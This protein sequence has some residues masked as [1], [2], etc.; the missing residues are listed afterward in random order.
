VHFFVGFSPV[1]LRAWV[2]RP[3]HVEDGDR[4]GATL[5]TERYRPIALAEPEIPE[6]VLDQHLRALHREAVLDFV[7]AVVR[8]HVDRESPI[9]LEELKDKTEASF[10]ESVPHVAR[11][12]DEVLAQNAE[13]VVTD[14]GH[15]PVVQLKGGSLMPSASLR[16]TAT[17]RQCGY[18]AWYDPRAERG[19][20]RAASGTELKFS[21]QHVE[22][23]SRPLLKKRRAH[24]PTVV[25]FT[26]SEK[27]ESAVGVK[28]LDDR[29][30]LRDGAF[31]TARELPRLVEA[32]VLERIAEA[33]S[34]QLG[35][36]LQE[37][38][39]ELEQSFIGGAR[40][41]ERL[42]FSS[43]AAYLESLS[44]VALDGRGGRTVVGPREQRAFGRL[45]SPPPP[46]AHGSTSLK[47]VP[48]LKPSP[49]LIAKPSSPPQ[50][51]PQAPTG[52]AA[53]E[54]PPPRPPSDPEAAVRPK[55]P[56][57]RAKQIIREV[58]IACGRNGL[59]LVPLTRL[60]AMCRERADPEGS[61]PKKLATLVSSIPDLELVGEGHGASARLRASRGD[62]KQ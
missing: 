14:S 35:L 22:A 29:M 62:A 51:K 49:K 33:R 41:C 57:E 52:S 61:F 11:L 54:R 58:V 30:S 43:L 60:G 5:D 39:Q 53:G 2:V 9:V 15:G 6:E 13:F 46:V 21:L 10:V 8:A 17:A 26:L 25:E 31:V 44:T 37:L 23:A 12:V 4:R 27:S 56:I 42:G 19:G 18:V 45:A 28:L 38:E 48:S 20:I 47:K 59:T 40:L 50:A 36:F 34:A 24:R 32:R 1:G 55:I 16:P 3:G 7:R